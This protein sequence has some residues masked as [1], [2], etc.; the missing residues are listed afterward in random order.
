[1]PVLPPPY[2]IDALRKRPQPDN[3]PQLELPLPSKPPPQPLSERGVV[4]VDY[5]VDFE[6]DG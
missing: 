6:I 1:M 3:R 2:I 4:E 5:T